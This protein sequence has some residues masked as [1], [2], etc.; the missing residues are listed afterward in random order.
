MSFSCESSSLEEQL[1]LEKEYCIQVSGACSSDFELNCSSF[2]FSSPSTPTNDCQEKVQKQI[3]QVKETPIAVETCL[4]NSKEQIECCP[5]PFISDDNGE[6][7]V[8]CYQYLFG[9][10]LEKWLSILRCFFSF[11]S[12]VILGIAVLPQY[13]MNNLGLFLC[14]SLFSFCIFFN[15][16]FRQ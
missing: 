12:L 6:C 8:E 14:F 3:S 13:F 10:T 2:V 1:C 11:I 15:I 7:V 9:E 4:N 5:D 16:I